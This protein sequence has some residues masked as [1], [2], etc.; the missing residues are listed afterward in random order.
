MIRIYGVKQSRASRC[1]WLLEEMGTPY[2]LVPVNT[3]GE[4]K[5]DTYLA[6]NPAGKV[7]ALTSDGF[8]MS[9]SHAINLWLAQQS[10]GKFWPSAAETQGRI[11]QWTVWT[12]TELEPIT[13]A[14][15]RTKRQPPPDIGARLADLVA[16]AREKI[17][18]V[19]LRLETSPYLA[20]P[21][22]TLADLSVGSSLVFAPFFGIP[23]DDFPRVSAW[24]SKLKGR[25]A[26]QKVFGG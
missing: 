23:L 17:G 24:I 25:A 22:F 16:Q 19:E 14:I 1:L 9:E 5:T 10:G 3:T 15:L 4:N 2:E 7:P 12:G 13:N 26:Y 20:G 8:A 21:E 11:L 6:I 18:L